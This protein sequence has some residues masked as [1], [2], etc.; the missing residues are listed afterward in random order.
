M[1]EVMATGDENITKNTRGASR[2]PPLEREDN[3]DGGASGIGPKAPPPPSRL[4]EARES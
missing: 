1:Q 3:T 2:R 4:D